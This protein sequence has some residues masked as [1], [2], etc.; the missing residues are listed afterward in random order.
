MGIPY[1]VCNFSVSLKLLQKKK[2]FKVI[3]IGPHNSRMRSA[4]LRHFYTWINWGAGRL[5]IKMFLSQY[6]SRSSPCA[7]HFSIRMKASWEQGC[8]VFLINYISAVLGTNM[9]SINICCL[10]EWCVVMWKNRSGKTYVHYNWIWKL[11]N[12]N[13]YISISYLYIV[14][15]IIN[16]V[17]AD[18]IFKN[19]E[20]FFF[21]LGREE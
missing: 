18:A 5:S 9:H 8:W 1:N 12:L 19:T 15:N 3:V 20:E 13:T 14:Y 10:Y 6:F 16:S 21:F 11:K 2:C 4:L 7:L 17:P